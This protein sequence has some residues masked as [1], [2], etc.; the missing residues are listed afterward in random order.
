VIKEIKITADLV[1][2]DE[3][4][5]RVYCPELDISAKGC[6]MDDAFRNLEGA[7][8]FFLDELKTRKYLH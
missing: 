2:D 8:R 3:G 4:T 5:Y 1:R 7:I 6:D